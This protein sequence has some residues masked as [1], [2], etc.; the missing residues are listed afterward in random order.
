MAEILTPDCP[1]CGEPPLWVL[2][3]GTQAFCSGDECPVLTWDPSAS[4]AENLLNMKPV[5][6]TDNSSDE[7]S[8]DG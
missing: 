3:G 5:T 6:L 2:G 1:V 8:G 7:G 4:A